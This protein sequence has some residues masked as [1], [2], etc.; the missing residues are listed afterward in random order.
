MA[1]HFANMPMQYA[2][3]FK[4]L[5]MIILDAKNVI[6]FAQ[7]IDSGYTLEPRVPTIYVLEQE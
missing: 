3:I 4:V 6:P 7:Y 1:L 5:K 2:A